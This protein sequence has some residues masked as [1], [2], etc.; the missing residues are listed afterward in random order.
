[1]KKDKIRLLAGLGICLV[2]Y[3]LVVFLVPFVK[4]PVFWTSFLFTLVAFGLVGASFYIAFLLKPDA[5]SRFYGF[6]IAR[7]G[8]IYGAAQLIA[9]FL[10]MALGQWIPTWLAVLVYAIGLGLTAIGLI[11][12]EAVVEQI[13]VQDVQQKKDVTLMRALQS[14][15]SQMAGLCAGDPDLAALV[16]EFAEE[17]RYSDPVS[18]EAIADA[19]A[20][21]SA[22][23]D[24][25]HSALVDGDK[26][27]ARTLCRKAAVLLAE[28]NR[29]CKLNKGK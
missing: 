21:L 1:M 28:R 12:A 11:S 19:E 27:A 25:L 24:E 7:I 4:T 18:S 6:P 29:L 13:Q 10:F 14:K 23:V 5:K 9:C 20:D 16:K 8:A 17:M 26:A 3:I 15:V 2:L 22:A